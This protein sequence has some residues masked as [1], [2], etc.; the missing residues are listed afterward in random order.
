MSH[1]RRALVICITCL[2]VTCGNIDGTDPYAF[3]RTFSHPDGAFHFHCLL[4]P[5]EE[6]GEYSSLRPVLVLEP[7]DK[8]G[9]LDKLSPQA[10]IRLEAWFEN[11]ESLTLAAARRRSHWQTMG[12]RVEEAVKFRNRVDDKG[13]LQEARVED[14]WV[15]EVMFVHGKGVVIISLWG[16]GASDDPDIDLLLNGF[17]PR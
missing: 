6:Y 1:V 12:Y 16:R 5:W 15:K 10:R 4:P 11:V 14:L 2:T 13:I 17:E 8:P 7:Y 3:W 9:L